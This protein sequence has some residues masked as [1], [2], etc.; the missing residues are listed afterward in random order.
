MESHLYS[1]EFF[2]S[3]TRIFQNTF[4]NIPYNFFFMLFSYFQ[5]NECKK[6]SKFER[7]AKSNGIPLVQHGFFFSL[8][9]RIFLYSFRNFPYNF[10]L[11][12][13]RISRIMNVKKS[14]NSRGKT[15]AMESHFFTIVYFFL[16]RQFSY[17]HSRGR[18]CTTCVVWHQKASLPRKE[19]TT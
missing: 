14:R 3:F 5:N 10:L 19:R 11:Q 16:S 8:S 12:C 17:E 15:R 7:E 2:F 13:V 18:Q 6:I 4:R 9:P 1:M